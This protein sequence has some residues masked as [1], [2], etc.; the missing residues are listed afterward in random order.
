MN[1]FFSFEDKFVVDFIIVLKLK[2]GGKFKL[3]KGRYNIEDV[4]YNK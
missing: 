4:F 2:E 3:I 1:E